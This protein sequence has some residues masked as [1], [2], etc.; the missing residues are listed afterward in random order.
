VS[1]LLLDTDVVSF[2]LKRDD[3][4]EL[5]RPVLTGRLLVVSFMTVAE[6]ERWALTRNWGA[7]RRARLEE[8]LRNFIIHP[9]DRALCRKWAE[10]TPGSLP[11]VGRSDLFRPA[12]GPGHFLRRRVDSRYRPRPRNASRNQQRQGLRWSHRPEHHYGLRT[13]VVPWI[14]PAESFATIGWWGP[15]CAGASG[16]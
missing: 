7:R 15:A 9:F 3:R 12:H 8:H 5:Y 1:A 13:R 2:L 4:A 14:R 16:C 11:E 6:L 10:V